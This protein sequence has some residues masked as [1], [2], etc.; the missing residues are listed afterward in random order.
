[1]GSSLWAGRNWPSRPNSRLYLTA[2]GRDGGAGV[3]GEAHFGGEGGI[4][5]EQGN[6]GVA[7]CGAITLRCPDVG[8]ERN[9]DPGC[10]H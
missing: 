5:S 8:H 3:D 4:I 7:T 6:V 2:V 1:M 9:R 10:D